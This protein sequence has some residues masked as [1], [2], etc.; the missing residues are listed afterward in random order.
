MAL[1]NRTAVGPL[2]GRPEVLEDADVPAVQFR[3][4]SKD[5]EEGYPGTVTLKVTYTLTDA[6]ELRIEYEG[7]TDK[8]TILNPTQHSYFN[9]SGDFSKLLFGE[10]EFLEKGRI[11]CFGF[12]TDGHPEFLVGTQNVRDMSDHSQQTIFLGDFVRTVM[13]GGHI[14]EGAGEFPAF[15]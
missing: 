12:D 7:E 4:T 10:A 3:Y 11:G 6:N 2:P 5:G 14:L 15:G 8:P 9:L 13:V 1:V